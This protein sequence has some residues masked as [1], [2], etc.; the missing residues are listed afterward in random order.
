MS[1]MPS[2]N[3]SIPGSASLDK[4]HPD[5]IAKFKSDKD[6]EQ[7]ARW[8]TTEYGKMKTARTRIVNQWNLQLAFYYGNQYLEFTKG[9]ASLDGKMQVPKAPPH[10]IRTTIN[11]IRPMIR[12]ELSRV[13]QQKP[14]ASVVPASAEDED[15]AAA[16]AAEQVWESVSR[17]NGAQAVFRQAA[18]WMLICGTGFTKTWWDSTKGPMGP[19]PMNLMGPPRPM[20]DICFGAVTPYH[21]FV[22][23][24]RT[25]AIQEQPYVLNVYTKNMEWLRS[26]YGD[27]LTGMNISP[28]VVASSEI[29]SDATLNLSGAKAEPDSVLC[30]EMWVKPGAHKLMPK[31]GLIHVIGNQVVY[32]S[33]EGIPYSHEQFPFTKLD[34]I[35]TGKFYAESSIFDTM[36]LQREYNR[37]RSQITESK[38]RMAKPQLLIQK[39]SVDPRKITTEPGLA[40]EYLPGMNPPTPLPLVSLPNYVLEEQDRILSDIEDISG[41]HQVSKGGAPAGVTAATAIS[42]LQE[43][44]DGIL[45]PTYA[46][47]EEGWE[48][49][50]YQTLN[51]VVQ[52][53]DTERM[54]KTVGTDGAFDTMLL[55]GADLKNSTDIRMEGGSALPVSKAARQA[56]I[57][58][59]M[60]MGFIAPQDGL[61]ILDVG[62]VQKLWEA[63]RRDESQAQRENIKLKKSD[64]QMLAQFQAEQ[65]QMQQEQMAAE[66]QNGPDMATAGTQDTEPANGPMGEGTAPPPM[67]SILP[68]NSWDNHA[69]HIET[70]NNFRKSQAFELLAPEIKAEF[71]AHVNMHVAAANQAMAQAMA[72]QAGPQAPGAPGGDVGGTAADPAAGQPDGQDLGNDAPPPPNEGAQK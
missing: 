8:V 68:V 33:K 53:W 65:Q 49:I 42:F 17:T 45:A 54:V 27:K 20:G 50:A 71:E 34:H 30:Y 2:D 70:H 14:N 3:S 31:G 43:K 39:G 15:L 16:Y 46:S 38:N 63:L 21:L 12:T 67:E 64:P 9:I 41:Q 40:I 44:D 35:P 22:P 6:D 13:T 62:G 57:M 37:T 10:R 5:L 11:R 52:M 48:N 24:L 18:F 60:K 4:G 72:A 23:D 66:A 51:L 55:K 29:V 69:V 61:K 1:Q 47:I 26:F 58:D 36:P 56:F 28:D 19:D 59:M 7:L 25:V 32:S